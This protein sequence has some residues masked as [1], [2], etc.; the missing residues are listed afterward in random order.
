[1][2]KEGTGK[3]HSRSAW[4]ITTWDYKWRP[5]MTHLYPFGY[6]HPMANFI[7]SILLCICA[8]TKYCPLLFI[9]YIC[10]ENIFNP[11]TMMIKLLKCVIEEVQGCLLN[12]RIFMCIAKYNAPRASPMYG[13]YFEMSHCLVS[14]SYNCIPALSVVSF[15]TGITIH[16][17]VIYRDIMNRS[18]LV[19]TLWDNK[20]Q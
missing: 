19:L 5:I 4:S 2:C 14:L 7:L 13:N 15:L 3:V 18:L 12:R 11:S 10:W 6:M 16:W 17:P 20:P 9:K 8:K 1:M